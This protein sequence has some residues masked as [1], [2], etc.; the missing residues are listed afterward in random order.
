M[1]RELLPSAG[2]YPGDPADV[3]DQI[4]FPTLPERPYIFANMVS[5]LDGKAQVNGA[6]AGLGSALDQEIMSHLRS[7]ADGILEGAG[8]VRADRIYRYFPDHLL[9][10]RRRRGQ[11]EHPRWMVVTHSGQV[12]YDSAIF[13]LPEDPA[14]V[15]TPRASEVTQNVVRA[16]GRCEVV[17]IP[18][19]GSLHEAL[20]IL[21][22]RYQIRWLL[23]EGGPH[24]LYSLMKQ[25]V[26]DEL[27]L[28][29]AP[30]VIAG[31]GMT[32]VEGA[33]L[34]PTPQIRTEIL[35][36]YEHDSELFVRCRL[37]YQ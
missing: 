8:T 2:E 14:L 35:N 37:C 28:T 21:R 15:L 20:A 24:F 13:R 33:L 5:S 18:S 34:S 12:P 22:Q 23:T 11:K 16:G 36:L 17:S 9:Q 7:L 1:L 10:L 4:T 19:D 6:A 27:F 26:L 3:Y 25:R 31:E 29:L 30:K 32:I